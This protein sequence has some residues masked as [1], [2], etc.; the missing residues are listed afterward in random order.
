MT[1]KPE[2]QPLTID[3]VL[4]ST[5]GAQLSRAS[6][7]RKALAIA[8]ETVTCRECGL[9]KNE[10]EYEGRTYDT[11]NG[12]IGTCIDCKTMA[13]LDLVRHCKAKS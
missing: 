4:A 10:S 7:A 13:R 3:G 12:R 11:R 1:A 2:K 9:P 6:A 5:I 8:E